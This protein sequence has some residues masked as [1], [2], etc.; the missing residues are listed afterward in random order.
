VIEDLKQI[1]DLKRSEITAAVLSSCYAV[2]TKLESGGGAPTLNEQAPTSGDFNRVSLTLE[3]GTMIE[4]LL[5]NET[6]ESFTPSRPNPEFAPFY[7]A[8]AKEMAP[9]LGLSAGVLLRHFTASYSASRGELLQVLEIM[10]R[11][12]TARGR[13]FNQVIY[14][15]MCTEAVERAYVG[16]RGWND[17]LSRQAWTK[18][19]WIGPAPGQLNPMDEVQAAELMV[20]AGFSTEEEQTAIL[21]GGDYDANQDQ[22]DREIARRRARGEMPDD[23]AL[24]RA[25][26]RSGPSDDSDDETE[27]PS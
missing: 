23:Q 7:E 27:E 16:L 8:I 9:A 22:R 4:G 19:R 26:E 18:A 14:S 24:P 3:P 6:I 20:K 17:V 15:R 1:C 12:R 2:V 11:R 5:P 10:L 21:T 25:R 13:A